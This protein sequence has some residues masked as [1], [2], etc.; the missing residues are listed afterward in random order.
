LNSRTNRSWRAGGVVAAGTDAANQLLIPGFSEHEEMA[1]LVDA[2]LTPLEAITAATR[3]GA[4]VLKA[5][6]LGI[7]APGN[8]ADLVVLNANPARDIAATHNI[9]WVMTRGRVVWP[10]SLRSAWKK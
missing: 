6:S 4:Q 2:G 9:A 3:R 7:V 5:D 8:V 10:D 1:L